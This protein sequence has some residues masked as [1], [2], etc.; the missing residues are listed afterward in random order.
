MA[1]SLSVLVS[2]R[3]VELFKEGYHCSE[4]VLLAFDEYT[5]QNYP[6]SVKRGM[7]AF[8]EGV[9]GSGCICGALAGAVFVLSTLG[10]R[11]SPN[12]STKQLESVIKR[13]HD[14]FRNEFKSACCRVITHNSSRIFGIGKYKNCHK[15]VDFCA[16]RIVELA[17]EQGWIS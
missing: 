7:S 15:T 5:G 8:V 13:L 17:Q 1:E 3:A 4:S 12:E 6:D 2:L 14:D 9:G 10:G 11:T 16:T